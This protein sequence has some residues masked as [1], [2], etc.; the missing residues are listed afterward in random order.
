MNSEILL[1]FFRNL[2]KEK[3]EQAYTHT[4]P[5]LLVSIFKAFSSQLKL[6]GFPTKKKKEPNRTE[7]QKRGEKENPTTTRWR[8]PV[9][10]KPLQG[11]VE[12]IRRQIH[13]LLVE[14]GGFMIFPYFFFIENFSP[15]KRRNNNKKTVC[16]FV[17]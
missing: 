1:N 16:F 12:V 13:L 8:K 5:H 3:R 17:L 11:S 10:R 15:K 14:W 7:P 6:Q 4:P 2:K 9:R